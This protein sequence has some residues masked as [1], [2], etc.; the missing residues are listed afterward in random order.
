MLGHWLELAIARAAEQEQFAFTASPL[1]DRSRLHYETKR[2][3]GVGDGHHPGWNR[4]MSIWPTLGVVEERNGARRHVGR[5]AIG[6]AGAA[7]EHGE[8]TS[9]T[10]AGSHAGHLALGSQPGGRWQRSGC[11][12]GTN[13]TRGVAPRIVVGDA[14]QRADGELSG[15]KFVGRQAYSGPRQARDDNHQQRPTCFGRRDGS[16]SAAADSRY[17]VRSI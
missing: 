8:T 12:R 3:S 5:R 7:F 13:D 11:R 14:C 6:R 15:R 10:G 2:T 1:A 9:R 17:C 4:R 16:T